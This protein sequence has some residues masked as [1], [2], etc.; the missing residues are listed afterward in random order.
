MESDYR[1][2]YTPV[3]NAGARLVESKFFT[4]S[5]YDIDSRLRL[6]YSLLD[7]FVILI[8]LK[9][10]AVLTDNEGYTVTLRGGETV[11]VPAMT[12]ALQV[13]GEIKMLETYV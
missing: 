6:D 7:S 11:L 1:T 13:E 3:K 2:R 9:G 5:V 4:T 10:E 8:G 12:T